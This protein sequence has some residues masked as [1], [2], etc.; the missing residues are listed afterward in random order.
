MV[1]VNSRTPRLVLGGLTAFVVAVVVLAPFV[2]T[3][4]RSISSGERFWSIG[5]IGAGVLSVVA[6]GTAAGLAHSRARTAALLACTGLL[7]ELPGLYNENFEALSPVGAGVAL[8]AITA[9]IPRRVRAA[10]VAGVLAGVFISDSLLDPAA[11]PRRYANL[12]AQNTAQFQPPA[13]I[14]TVT[15]LV[16]TALT[17]LAYWR[18]GNDRDP[19][20]PREPMAVLPVVVAGALT[21]MGVAVNWWINISSVWAAVPVVAFALLVTVIAARTLEKGGHILLMS[22]ASAATLASVVANSLSAS[23]KPDVAPSTPIALLLCALIVIAAALASIRPSVVTGYCA[24]G[25]LTLVGIVCYAATMAVSLGGAM[26]VSD[27]LVLVTGAAATYAIVSA[28]QSEPRRTGASR[29]LVGLGVIFGPTAFALLVYPQFT[30]GWTDYTAISEN[31]TA[32]RFEPSGDVVV[33]GVT[34]LVSVT[35]CAC[36]S[37]RLRRV[38]RSGPSPPSVEIL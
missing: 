9:T 16:L 23:V 8:G 35:V 14:A 22:T 3:Q 18:I 26:A 11:E 29:L 30:Y 27:V 34:A 2:D 6:V 38:S 7:I 17:T 15:A 13:V 21:L 20:E 32:A 10:S 5:T 33:L 37:R 12:L 4:L 24:L 28:M 25:V 36:A 19:N 1:H 31:E